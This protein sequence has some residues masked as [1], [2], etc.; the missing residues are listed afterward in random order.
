M[1]DT[2]I[3]GGSI[4]TERNVQNLDVAI[5]D[6][7]IAALIQPGSLQVDARNVID[8]TGQFVLPGGID[9]HVHFDFAVSEVMRAQSAEAGA[10]AAAFGGT[11][12]YIDFA[13]Q[14]G[15]QVGLV[16][17]IEE[18]LQQTQEQPVSIDFA[19]HAILSGDFPLGV[20]DE[21]KAAVSGGVVSFKLFTTFRGSQT[22]GGL[23]ADDGRIYS[24]MGEAVKHSAEVMVHCE[25]DCIIDYNVRRL[26]AEGREQFWNIVEARPALA[27]EAAVNRMVLLSRRTGCPLYV[28][29]VSAKDTLECIR[30]AR[31]KGLLVSCEVLHPQL[32]FTPA[33]YRKPQG[34]RY[35]NYPANKSDADR[36]ALWD[37]CL[38]GSLQTMASDDYTIPLENKLVGN[39][40]DNCTGGTNSVETRMAVFWSEG[41]AKRKMDV[42]RFVEMTA[43][44]PARLFGIYGKKGVIAPGAD[45]NIVIVNPNEHHTFRQGQNLHSD[46]D[47]SNWDGWETAGFPVVT[48]LR[49]VVLVDHGKWV[50]P[51]GLGQFVPAGVPELC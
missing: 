12:T 24:V 4:V 5:R 13:F 46:C 49:G 42:R 32:L 20:T 7:K 47:Y 38:D 36:E 30:E 29:H 8:A 44:N 45:A 21:I 17:A 18:K 2:V 19:L 28:V 22:I 25:D 1:L 43:A 11:T 39:T 16:Q 3:K 23:Y 40:V 50:G 31:A 27:E 9:G 10:R 51:E 48:M 33:D 35:M 41:V 14:R 37:G 26:Y 15:T 34:Q 6:G